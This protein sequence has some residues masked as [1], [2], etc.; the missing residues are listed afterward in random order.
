MHDNTT[1]DRM[2]LPMMNNA[3]QHETGVKTFL[4]TTIPAGTA[5]PQSLTLALDA[6]FAHPNLPPFVSQAADPA[7]RHLQP[8]AG[9]CRRG[10]R[11]CS[12]T[13]AAACAAT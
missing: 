2:R 6:I 8:V 9:L 12:S 4:G 10:S 5:G 13:M 1:P 7:A 3:A 11:R